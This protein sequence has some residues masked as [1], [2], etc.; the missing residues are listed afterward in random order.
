MALMITGPLLFEHLWDHL[1]RKDIEYNLFVTL[2]LLS[3][4]MGKDHSIY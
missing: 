4:W 3:K 2:N 1:D